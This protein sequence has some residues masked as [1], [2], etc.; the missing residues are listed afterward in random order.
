MYTLYIMGEKGSFD[1]S[2][3]VHDITYT[4]TLFGQ[5]GKLTFT[6]EKDPNG[7]L[8]ISNGNK[9]LFFDNDDFVF[10]GNVFTMGTDRT[11]A[12]SITA[13]DQMRYLQ[14]HD[15]LY[16]DGEENK[17]LQDI[18]VKICSQMGMTYAIKGDAGS[19]TILEPHLFID[20]SYFDMLQYC[21]E[22]TNVKTEKMFF[23]R[24]RHG[25]L[26]LDE[27]RS[28]FAVTHKGDP[29]VIGNGSLLMDYKYEVDIDKET[30]NEVYLLEDIKT[31]STNSDKEK[32]NKKL[33]LAQQD[34]EGIKKWGTLRK[35][36]NVNEQA[37]EEQLKEYAKLSLEIG[38][39]PS[40]TMRLES[41]GYPVYAG[42]GFRLILDRLNVNTD[43]Y[44]MGA[45]HTYGEIHTMSLD[46][47]TGQYLPEVL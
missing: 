10:S 39:K 12:Y 21:I 47:S 18:F 35:I 25:V 11:E 32:T 1:V 42:D 29:I 46:V 30:W 26:E 5:A 37:T 44:I 43:I 27:V 16:L 19:Q 9:V 2:S 20:Q 14:N 4:T 24:D 3:L 41:L 15:Y 17:C 23:I 36:V 13:Y 34:A 7:I 6:L 22:E 8:T 40:K 38:S 33:V 31:S 45:T 28:N